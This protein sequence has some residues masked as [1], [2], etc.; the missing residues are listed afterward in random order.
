MG[1][2]E[3]FTQQGVEPSEIGGAEQLSGRQAVA[4]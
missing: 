1:M 4:A 2:A 3:R